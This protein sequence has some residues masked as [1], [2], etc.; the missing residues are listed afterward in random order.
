[1]TAHRGDELV[2]DANM[3]FDR[4]RDIPAPP[5]AIWPWIVQLGKH[6]AGWYAPRSV[7][8]LLP[9]ARRATRSIRPDFQDLA[10]GD[11]IPDYGGAGAHLQVAV[12]EPP[13]VLIYRDRRRGAP[14]SWAITLTPLVDGGETRVDLRFRGRIR[15]IGLL[16]RVILGGG[17]LFDGLTAEIMLRGLAERAVT[18]SPRPR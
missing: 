10:V 9:P 14:F 15:S 3:I 6:R 1:M 4:R 8:R 13:R 7:E 5:A 17:E 12:I 11:R 2:P 16:R 18:M